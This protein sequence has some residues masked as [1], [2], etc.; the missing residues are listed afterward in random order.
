MQKPRNLCCG[1]LPLAHCV[2]ARLSRADKSANLR[3]AGLPLLLER[4]PAHQVLAVPMNLIEALE[5]PQVSLIHRSLGIADRVPEHVRLVVPESESPSGKEE[6]ALKRL[7]KALASA[8]PLESVS[9]LDQGFE[10]RILV[11]FGFGEELVGLIQR[12]VGLADH[13]DASALE[14]GTEIV[15]DPDGVIEQR[16]INDWRLF[17]THIFFKAAF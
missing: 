9:S 15:L 14:Q 5:L 6:V 3:F 8:P 7:G 4:M 16:V 1:A 12:L 11:E 2:F 10:G 13:V 17:I